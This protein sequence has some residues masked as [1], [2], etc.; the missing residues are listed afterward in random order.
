MAEAPDKSKVV[1]GLGKSLLE[2]GR[3]SFGS[4]APHKG[5]NVALARQWFLDTIRSKAGSVL[6]DLRGVPFAA[7]IRSGIPE[8]RVSRA[9]RI[10]RPGNVDDVLEAENGHD[11]W[12]VWE[13]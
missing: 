11:L 5:V 12:D 7:F 4:Y 8:L 3:L 9:R 10:V 1:L 13:A 6:E 2:Q